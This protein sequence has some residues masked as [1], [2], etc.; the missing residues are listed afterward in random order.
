MNADGTVVGV[1]GITGASGASVKKLLLTDTLPK[2]WV[3]QNILGDSK[4]LVFAGTGNNGAVTPTS[5]IAD[6]T[7]LLSATIT[8]KTATEGEKLQLAFQKWDSPYAIFVKAKATGTTLDSYFA[9]NQTSEPTNVVTLT[10]QANHKLADSNATVTVKSTLLSKTNT[11][12]EDGVLKWTV[13][14]CP[15]K[16]KH[17][18]LDG[19]VTDQLPAGMEL[20]LTKDGT[21]DLTNDNITIHKLTLQADGSYVLGEAVPLTLGENVSYDAN[22]RKLV[23]QI[24]DKEQA[25]RFTYVTDVSA[26]VNT[27][28]TNQVTL[29]DT[30]NASIIIQANYSVSGSDA[31]ATMHRSGYVDLTKKNESGDLLTGA[32]FI[33]YGTKSG[34]TTLDS[35][36]VIRTGTTKNGKLRMMGIPLGTYILKETKAP[37]GYLL[38][39]EEHLVVI[40][41]DNEGFHIQIDGHAGAA[42]ELQ[43]K[44]LGTIGVQKV[45][46][47]TG[48]KLS[49]ASLEIRKDA[50]TSPVTDLDHKLAK[51]TSSA[52][53]QY[54]RLED[55]SYKLV[56]TAAPEYYGVADAIPFVIKDGQLVATEN[57]EANVLS[58]KDEAFTATLSFTKHDM[59]ENGA[60]KEALSGAEFVL[61]KGDAELQRVTSD[62]NGSVVI[63]ITS[64]G[65]YTLA[66]TKAPSGYRAIEPIT[67]TVT[68][69]QNKQML[70]VVDGAVQIA[71]NQTPGKVGDQRAEGTVTL[72]KVDGAD[73]K[74]IDGAT[75]TLYKKSEE[76]NFQQI[77]NFLTGKKYEKVTER[78]WNA[79]T[80]DK[81]YIKITGLTWGEYYLKETAPADGYKTSDIEYPFSIGKTATEVR[82]SFDA[83]T[84]QNT[85]T[86]VTFHKAGLVNESCSKEPNM[87]QPMEGVTFTAYSD[88][89]LTDSVQK[90]TSD[91]NGDVTFYKLKKG[92]TYYIKETE[93]PAKYKKQEYTLN[94]EVYVAELDEDG[95][96]SGLKTLKQEL[97]PD[98]TVINDVHRAKISFVKVDEKHTDRVVANSTYGLYKLQKNTR[99]RA[100]S[101]E[102]TFQYGNQT[103][104]KLAEA[105]TDETGYIAFDGVLMNEEYLIRELIAPNGCYVSENPMIISYKVVESGDGNSTIAIDRIEKGDGTITTDPV[106]GEITWLEPHVEVQISKTDEAG[107]LLSGASLEIRDKDN[108]TVESWISSDKEPYT[109]YGVLNNGE[110]YTLVETKAPDGY[111]VSDPVTF[112][113]TSDRIG[114]NQNLVQKITMVDRKLPVEE[115]TNPD[116]EKNTPITTTDTGD[117][118]YQGWYMLIGIGVILAAI[119]IALM[120]KRVK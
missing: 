41:K 65:T 10:D 14:Y 84:I 36:K 7:A 101:E 72:K 97:V 100:A 16:L 1:D 66:E 70:T 30:G 11:K 68:D 77:F 105:T 108:Q 17:T 112:T 22:S 107:Q 64:K 82:L 63:P 88:S 91:A 37:E 39:N 75:F 35:S 96:F 54:F 31:T 117:I 106:T 94:P 32:E 85:R 33:L 4:Y 23:F 27:K 34:T 57:S 20:R 26:E 102:D 15:Y 103:Y 90:V 120:R 59:N 98:N 2:G 79:Q 49:G 93:I 78:E 118:W 50:E 67:F 69:A 62:E 46:A 73:D 109:S 58:M 52:E 47:A 114:P 115:Q 29:S 9:K 18:S 21:L 81:G 56:E 43:N 89:T 87:T 71:K 19:K 80:N 86:E 51:W 13:D 111:A 40:N 61:K 45:S 74:A 99:I 55:G 8:E 110:T 95:A 113:I 24:A 38:S 48:E 104:V 3:F 83:G 116:G 42:V 5:Y 119:G 25:Y 12:S 6:T 60:L 53:T 28:L 76:G 92:T 44:K